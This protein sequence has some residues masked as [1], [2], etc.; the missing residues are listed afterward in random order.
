MTTFNSE[1][2][3]AENSDTEPSSVIRD[4]RMHIASSNLSHEPGQTLMY[5]TLLP[6]TNIQPALR[7]LHKLPVSERI[8]CTLAFA[9]YNSYAI[10]PLKRGYIQLGS[11]LVWSYSMRSQSRSV[12]LKSDTYGHT[13]LNIA[14]KRSIRIT[15]IIHVAV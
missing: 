7:S 8:R 5:W 6:I 1:F 3:T 9:A 10:S 12:S 14:L 4:S 11:S 13:C 15:I 2:S